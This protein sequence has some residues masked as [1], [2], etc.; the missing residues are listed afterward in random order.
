MAVLHFVPCNSEQLELKTR[1]TKP[2]PSLNCNRSGGA[3]VLAFFQLAG[4]S[5]WTLLG[6]ASAWFGGATLAAWLA[7][8]YVRQHRR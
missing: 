3:R 4:A 8:A 7:L 5:K 2:N 6:Y 1:P